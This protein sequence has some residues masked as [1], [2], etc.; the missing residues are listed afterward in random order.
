MMI[1][2]L[3]AKNLKNSGRMMTEKVMIQLGPKIYLKKA[4]GGGGISASAPRP[5]GTSEGSNTGKLIPADRN[6]DDS[7]TGK[8]LKNSGGVGGGGG[9]AAPP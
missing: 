7:I 4:A 9:A 5:H 2:Q 1:E 3:G 6:S 8:S